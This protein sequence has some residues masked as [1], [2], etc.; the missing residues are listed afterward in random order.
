MEMPTNERGV[1]LVWASTGAEDKLPFFEL[2][3][4]QWQDQSHKNE[5]SHGWHRSKFCQRCPRG[6]PRAVLKGTVGPREYYRSVFSLPYLDLSTME[7]SNS[8][9]DDVDNF[10]DIIRLTI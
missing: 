4:T 1:Q 5:G 9:L 6:T 7:Y 3:P 2:C 8:G 10:G